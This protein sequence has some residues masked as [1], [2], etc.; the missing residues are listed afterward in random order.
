MP[1]PE[2]TRQAQSGELL[3][4]ETLLAQTRRMLADPRSDAFVEGF[5]D[6]WLNL[7]SL[8]DMPPDRDAFERYYAEDLQN[9]MLR[10]THLFARHLVDENES[11]VRF[12]DSD[13]T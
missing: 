9:A 12:L 4:P 7:R 6:S 13:Y 1:D 11:I 5:V 2:L 8:G 3:A 10:E